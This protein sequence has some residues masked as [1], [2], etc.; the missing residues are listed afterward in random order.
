[1]TAR[2][3]RSG[4]V[5]APPFATKLAGLLV[6]LRRGGDEALLR[7]T[8]ALLCEERDLGNVCVLLTA[9]VGRTLPGHAPFPAAQDWRHG[10]LATGLCG[11]GE[12]DEPTPLVLRPDDRLYLLR[13][14][15]TERSLEAAL[16]TRLEA[17]DLVP[18][19]TIRGALQPLGLAAQPGRSEPDWQLAAITL[20]AQRPFALLCGGPGT[21]KTTT[22]ARLLALLLRVAPATR[23]ALAAPT[24]KA[25]ARLGEA[26]LARPETATF[27]AGA[28]RK[29]TTLHS[30]LGYRPLD[31][32]FVRGPDRPL[33]YDVVVVDEVS[34]IDPALLAALLAALRPNA[35]LLLVGD[36]DQL[37]AVAAG[38]VLGELTRDVVPG[39]VGARLAAFVRD[40]T[41]MELPVSADAPPI[42]DAAV[43][44]VTNHRFGADSGIGAFAAALAARR[45]EAAL[46]ALGSGRADLETTNDPAAALA[47]IADELVA[48]ARARDP[49]EALRLLSSVR[50]LCASRH[51]TL[52]TAAW[53]ERIEALL[54]ER[55]LRVEGPLYR[56]RPILV[57]ANDHQNH[58]WNGDL[59]VLHPDADGRTMAWLPGADGAPRA[60]APARLPPHETA[61]AMTVHK[62]QGSEFDTVLVSMPDRPG[63]SW[64]APL[65]YTAITRARRRAVLVAD[66]ALL[67]AA[68]ATWPTRTSGLAAGLARPR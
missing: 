37:A 12:H 40:A 46:A 20:A 27:P 48:A 23:I 60:I 5:D 4:P 33:S 8:V 58:V 11:D 51:G 41:G 29:P 38:Q 25:A 1:M 24:G 34:M 19:T 50:V 55:G 2:P 63:P 7:A 36:K 64:Q 21:G 42:A 6:R 66:P 57:L 32:S 49:A 44:L 65:V 26:L 59:A 9:H 35:R 53:N 43:A 22:V 47:T 39:R 61:W 14:W 68:L 16:R 17:A 56:G 10:L 18:A 15:R 67:P 52:G 45:P 28:V 31:D 54:R 30:L 13:H 62:S 3:D